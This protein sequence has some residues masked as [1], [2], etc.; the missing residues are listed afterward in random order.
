[1]FLKLSK[2]FIWIALFSVLIV[3]LGT[4]F[5]FIGGKY[6]FFRVAVELALASFLIWWAFEA[7]ANSLK[8]LF[9]PILENPLF[10]AVSVFVA[11]FLLASIFAYDTHAAF[12]S[13]YE[14][15][16]GGFQMLHY[17]IFFVL[18]TV[19]FREWSDWRLTFRASL[20]AA[21]GVILYGVASAARIGNFI[22]ASQNIP[23]NTSFWDLLLGPRFQG[24]LG[25]PAYVAPYL[26]FILF[27]GA[28]LWS[29][30]KIKNH[31]LKHLLYGGL[32]LFLLFF[33][34]LS[35]TRGGFLGLGAG[36]AVFFGYLIWTAP[37]LRKWLI[38]TLVGLVLILGALF[39]NRHTEF[40]HSLPISR[41][42]EL[43]FSE[44]TVQTRLWTW[45]SAWKGFKERPILGWGPENFSTV[46]DLHF[47]PRHFV[48]GQNSE[49]WFDRAHSVVFDYLAE[50]GLIGFL[51]YVSMFA[52]F[53]FLF[54]KFF[55]K[56]KHHK[57]STTQILVGHALLL[58]MPV[59]YLVQALALFDV[60]PIYLNLFLLLSFA[61]FIFNKHSHATNS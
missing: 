18:A 32:S 12:W 50:I 44:Q 23:A 37:K 2:L 26:L 7:S 31:W 21:S 42:F 58:A 27:F 38:G 9:T 54:F 20:V 52:T 10:I 28:Y 60:L 56:P 13:N 47:D 51:A 19:L 34:T 5:P 41:I 35:K 24:T 43:T 1:M 48:P 4:F 22:G 36:I 49:T 29:Q 6:Y 40:V 57:N 45:G 25:N 14:R 46:F 61:I 30:S 17:Y 55:I 33:F 53:Y 15:G 39:M 3:L 11:T 59:A 16:E 8:Q